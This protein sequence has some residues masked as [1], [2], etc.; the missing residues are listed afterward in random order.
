MAV[1]TPLYFVSGNLREMDAGMI[2]D[3]Q[4]LAI[5]EYA[6]NPSVTLSVSGSSGN[7][8]SINDTRL[9]AGSSLT[10]V[11]TFPSEAATAEPSTVTVSYQRILKT[12]ATVTATVDTGKTFP[13]YYNSAGNLQHMNATDFIDTFIA[14]AITT[15]TSGSTTTSQGGTYLVSTSTS[16]AGAALVSATPIFTD[17]RAD[18]SLY[19]A[20]GI[21]EDLDQPQTIT[22]YYLHQITGPTEPTLT[23]FPLYADSN[24]NIKEYSQAEIASVLASYIRREAASSV[25]G[26]SVDYNFDGT[27][28]ARG[29][30]IANTILIGG[31]GNYQT[32]QAG[33]DDYRAQEFPDG[34]PSTANTYIFKINKV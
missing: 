21:P 11:S 29:S 17:T 33:A 25:L 27:G 6:Q 22:N 20:A 15:L 8:T 5:Y 4:N 13:L 19:S 1:R 7:L 10:N 31:A 16:V 2:T 26:N 12:A 30:S 18:T 24:N 34:S 3:L 32:F 9:Q 28:T 14:P 23:T